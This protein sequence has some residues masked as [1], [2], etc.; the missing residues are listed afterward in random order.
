LTRPETTRLSDENAQQRRTRGYSWERPA[1]QR[2]TLRF[3]IPRTPDVAAVFGTSTP[4]AGVSAR[5]AAARFRLQR[6]QLRA[7]APLIW[8]TAW[9]W[10]KALSAIWARG[11]VPNISGNSL[12]GGM[13]TQPVK[14]W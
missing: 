3:C 2:L 7:L 8:Q 1:Q 13:E 14:V 12:K 11:H 4:P 5:A 9:A 10:L 6:K